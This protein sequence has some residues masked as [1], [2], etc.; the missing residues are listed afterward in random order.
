[1]SAWR[2]APCPDSCGGEGLSC[3]RREYRVLGTVVADDLSEAFVKANAFG[4][5]LLVEGDEGVCLKP[6]P[7]PPTVWQR[8]RNPSV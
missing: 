4:E 1:M 8:I 5:S 2:W 7:Q 3:C 6:D